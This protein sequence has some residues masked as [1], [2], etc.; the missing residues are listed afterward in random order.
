[1]AYVAASRAL[2][3]WLRGRAGDA[4]LVVNTPGWVKVLSPARLS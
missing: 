1:M 3:A 2:A 4:P